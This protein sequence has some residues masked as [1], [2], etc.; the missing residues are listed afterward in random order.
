MYL[1]SDGALGPDGSPPT[2]PPWLRRSQSRRA[3][4]DGHHG[5][6]VREMLGE[7]TT[8]VNQ[9]TVQAIFRSKICPTIPPLWYGSPHGCVR[10][11][12]LYGSL[13][14]HPSLAASRFRPSPTLPPL[15]PSL[16][17]RLSL[18]LVT[19]PHP[20]WSTCAEAA[21]SLRTWRFTTSTWQGS[22]WARNLR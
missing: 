17:R 3:L 10:S 19:L 5:W 13:M 7:A 4:A 22:S 1:V 20:R 6:V 21:A 9:R 2:H 18:R 15:P 16:A 8:S 12:S 11:S 14:M